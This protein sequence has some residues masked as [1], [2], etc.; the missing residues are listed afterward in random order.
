MKPFRIVIEV[1]EQGQSKLVFEGEGREEIKTVQVIAYMS[2]ELEKF[3]FQL[4]LDKMMEKFMEEIKRAN[5]FGQIQVI[6]NLPK[7]FKKKM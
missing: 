2:A 1:N 7:N 5:K 3:E 6:K 4:S